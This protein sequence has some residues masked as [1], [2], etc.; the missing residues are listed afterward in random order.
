[1]SAEMTDVLAELIDL[2]T[3]SLIGAEQYLGESQDLGWGSIFGGQVLGQA[4][5]AAAQTVDEGRLV[6]S[7]HG[8]FLRTGDVRHPVE[9]AVDRIRDGR[10]FT[11][12]TVVAK[13]HGRAIF[14]LAASFHGE[15]TGFD[16]QEPMPDVP[17]P[18]MLVSEWTM[19]RAISNQLPE[20]LKAIALK[21]RPI[22]TRPINP[23]NPMKPDIRPAKR[24]IWYRA[25]RQLSDDE[26][27]HR[28]LLAYISDFNFLAVA[29]QPHGVSWMSPGIR[30]ASL[31]HAIW[32]HR[33][34]RLDQ[35]LLHVV[36]S[37]S[38]AGGRGL[39]RGHIYSEDGRLIATTAQEGVIRMKHWLKD[40]VRKPM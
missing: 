7:M 18:E 14:N 19:A 23:V 36:E 5:S 6:H 38:A 34:F 9:Y 26:A 2:L 28:Y 10:S 29:L 30:M 1:M 12:R 33:P 24:M 15:E 4:L 13:Q 8:Y 35:W 25:A 37:P 39:V 11:T 20:K 17:N 27:L 3:P 16:H 22:E 21:T 32:F 40:D 31:D